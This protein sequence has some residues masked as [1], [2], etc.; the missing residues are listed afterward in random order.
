MPIMHSN[1]PMAN[2]NS[3]SIMQIK[4]VVGEGMD[5]GWIEDLLALAS[6]RSLG[7]AA[8]SRNV[9]QPAFSR[10]IQQIEQS[11]GVS[12]LD[13]SRRPAQVTTAIRSKLDE[14]RALSGNVKQLVTDFQRSGDVL[15]RVSIAAQHT[16]SIGFV[17]RFL[18]SQSLRRNNTL[19]QL[20]AANRD[21][22]YA[23]LMTRRVSIVVAYE[24]AQLP[25][26]PDENLM[27]VQSLGDDIFCPV[28]APRVAKE[29]RANSRKAKPLS[30]ILF[31]Q[32]SFFGDLFA[33][34]VAPQ[35]DDPRRYK[36]VAETALAPAIVAMTLAGAGIAWLPRTLCAPYLRDGTLV[37]L[38]PGLKTVPLNIVCARRQVHYADK[39]ADRIWEE[40][41]QFAKNEA[42]LAAI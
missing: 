42:R 12:V 18:S 31:P 11:L 29:S 1:I 26:A 6:S 33:C 4:H 30:L 40:L 5:I 13:R 21:E 3:A 24:A 39:T 37:Q 10:R 22:C 2:A 41:G 35:F 8:Q 14:I 32:G 38:H 36:I 17:A 23:S 27:E 20:H 16:I 34:G 7:D 15:N 9:T 19:I 28:A 25:L